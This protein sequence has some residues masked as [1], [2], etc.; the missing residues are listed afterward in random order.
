MKI[1]EKK[2]QEAKKKTLVELKHHP[3]EVYDEDAALSDDNDH[4]FI[5][6]DPSI[7]NIFFTTQGCYILLSLC[8]FIVLNYALDVS[9]STPKKKVK[10]S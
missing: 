8:I 9:E 6:D 4:L 3:D 5:Q 2:M 7:F 10:T 1:I